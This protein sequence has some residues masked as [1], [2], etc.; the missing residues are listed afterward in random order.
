MVT[1]WIRID[2]QWHHFTA[3]GRWVG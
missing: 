3:S 2:G 1:G